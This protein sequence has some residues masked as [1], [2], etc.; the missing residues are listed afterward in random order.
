MESP[1]RRRPPTQTSSYLIV[2]YINN[3]DNNKI[4]PTNNMGRAKKKYVVNPI[5]ENQLTEI[6]SKIYATKSKAELNIYL[7]QY[8][9]QKGL[10]GLTR[11]LYKI[12]SGGG[13]PPY[14]TTDLT[15][16]LV[17][18]KENERRSKESEPLLSDSEI[19]EDE[20]YALPPCPADV[21]F[22]SYN[23]TCY[24]HA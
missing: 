5:P 6:K 18:E 4:I 1:S 23:R 9:N 2:L 10:N 11:A 7:S 17:I 22:S 14:N 8:F 3:K 16:G 20:M 21:V 12:S 15:I 24:M 19:S 13:Y